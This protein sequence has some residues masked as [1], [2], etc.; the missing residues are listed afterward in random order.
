M[1]RSSPLFAAL[2]ITL[3][4][5][6]AAQAQRAPAVPA[7]CAD[8]YTHVNAPW[9][10]QHAL[11]PGQASFSRWDQLA[12][13]G[14]TRRAELLAATAAPEG[15]PASRAL[16]DLVASSQDEVAIEAAGT[17]ALKPLLDR[18][19]RIRRNRD[20]PAVVAALH[21]A[22]AP[23]LF[24]FRVRR[25]ERGQPYAELA[26]G[27]LGLPHPS[28]Y[29]SQEPEVRALDLRYRTAVSE[30]LR[31]S[32]SAPKKLA[33][34]SSWVVVMEGALAKATQADATPR[35]MPLAETAKATGAL[36]LGDFLAAQ[37][38][39][40]TEVALADPAFFAA[41]NEQLAKA[42]PEQWK[43]YLRAHVVRSLAPALPKGFRDPWT[44]VYEQ[45][46]A[47][48]AEPLP[49]ALWLREWLQADA[50]ELLDAAYDE[51]WL[52]AP[53]QARADAIAKAVRASAI[54]AVDGAAW[55]SD[56]GKARARE[57]LQAMEIQLGR[58]VPAEAFAGLRMRRDDFAGNVLA[59]RR[60]L[61]QNALQRARRAWPAE[62]WVPLLAWLPQENRLV[63]T[64][65][66]LQP[67]VLGDA[68]GAGDFGAFGGLLAQQVAVSLQGFDGPDA[69]AWAKRAQPLVAQYSAYS[70][71]G[72]ATRVNGT[73]GF[74][75][76]QADL[77]GLEL[78]WAALNAGGAPSPEAAKAF[79]TGWAAMW[80]RQDQAVPLAQAQAT[81]N[82]APAKWR[83]NGPL[84]N[85]PAFAATYGC[86][87]RDAML[88]PAKAQVA[89]W[90]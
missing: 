67:P 32:G 42:K 52:P 87:G 19:E 40:A 2:L 60:G 45:L 16:A 5:A 86:K 81:A 68:P 59:L 72:G 25:D 43:A 12:A 50:P 73:R 14:Q 31:L 64:T 89:L 69:A 47:G 49:R 1:R 28:F 71:T 88:K 13:L 77:A 15:L 78:A 38:L 20:V 33:E 27:G 51:R 79:F 26:P 11:E 74:A 6:P 30:W 8:F 70:A 57:R 9:L 23:V 46:L 66:V 75:Q 63:A 24:D 7:A 62:Q 22:G 36:A 35:R 90:R 61:H 83:V 4:T 37:G 34:E 3:A 18:I 56:A 39:K 41:V 55:L 48:R 44:N 10:A 82:H 53:R 54:A 85:L 58:Q 84:V 21:A 80:A 65:A 17:R 76:N 29:A